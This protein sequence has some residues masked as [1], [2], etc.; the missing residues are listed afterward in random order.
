LAE[1][2]VIIQ[3]EANHILTLGS[4]DTLDPDRDN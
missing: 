4:S 3:V 1:V 2:I